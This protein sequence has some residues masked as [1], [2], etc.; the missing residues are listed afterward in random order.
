MD[1]TIC[2]FIIYHTES[3]LKF[4]C[5]LSY[6][7]LDKNAPGLMVIKKIS[8]S[9]QVSMKFFLL[10]TVKMPTVVGILTFMGRK[11]AFSAYLG[12]KKSLISFYFYTYEHLKFHVQL[13]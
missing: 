8:C 11:T 5:W 1:E 4:Y 3:V 12:L 6:Q 10:I 13:S 2:D 9:T 7:V